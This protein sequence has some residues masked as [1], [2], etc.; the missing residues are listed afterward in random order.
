VN[1]WQSA[2]TSK[3][4]AAAT[5][6]EEEAEAR[7][8]VSLADGSTVDWYVLRPRDERRASRGKNLIRPGIAVL[9]NGELFEHESDHGWRPPLFGLYSTAARARVMLIIRPADTFEL[10]QDALRGRLVQTPHQELPWSAWGRMWRDVMPAEVGA[11]LPTA[12]SLTLNLQDLGRFFSPEWRQ[13]ISRTV[14]VVQ[15]RSGDLQGELL[16]DETPTEPPEPLPSSD[17]PDEKP[18]EETETERQPRQVAEPA[19]AE[20]VRRPVNTNSSGQRRGRHAKRAE[21]PTPRFLDEEEWPDEDAAYSF[22]YVREANELLI[23]KQSLMISDTADLWQSRRPGTAAP[24]IMQAVL[25]AFYVE[26]AG[27]IIHYLDGLEGRPGWAH[28]SRQETLTPEWLTFAALG[29]HALDQLIASKL[30]A[31]EASKPATDDG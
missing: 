23:R 27:K 11:F 9:H 24:M 15:H 4:D 28:R 7:S 21:I 17:K 25:D 12:G 31:S 16:A 30:D 13:R 26:L 20:R 29:F 14:R 3:L 5:L 18:D 22:R 19:L 1:Q 10:Q 6:L 8:T 2:R